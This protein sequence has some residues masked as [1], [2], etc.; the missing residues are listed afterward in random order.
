MSD[1]SNNN[2]ELSECISTTSQ[3]SKIQVNSLNDI[4]SDDKEEISAPKHSESSITDEGFCNLN[5]NKSNSTNCSRNLDYRLNLTSVEQSSNLAAVPEDSPISQMALSEHCKI[6][7]GDE[8]ICHTMENFNECDNFANE[9][10]AIIKN[11][12]EQPELTPSNGSYHES[13]KENRGIGSHHI[14]ESNAS[15]V[16]ECSIATNATNYSQRDRYLSQIMTKTEAL[17]ARQQVALWLTRTSM[18]DLSSMPSLKNLVYPPSVA[19]REPPSRSSQSSYCSCY[20]NGHDR[21]YQKKCN[22]SANCNRLSTAMSDCCVDG[23][24]TT[25]NNTHHRKC[26]A[27]SP[28]KVNLSDEKKFTAS[29]NSNI[30]RNHSTKSLI[31]GF[32]F[33]FRGVGSNKTFNDKS[34][35]MCEENK[36]LLPSPIAFRKCETVIALTGTDT[37]SPGTDAAFDDSGT[38]SSIATSTLIK[39]RHHQHYNR[40]TSH[41]CSVNNVRHHCGHGSVSPSVKSTPHSSKKSTSLSLLKKLSSSKERS[42]NR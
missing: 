29:K 1:I 16:S 10:S 38:Y 37:N 24:G 25:V 23:R 32:S 20:Y 34:E 17:T 27:T 41:S 8:N 28:S 5:D 4:C 39:R 18:S 40:P 3:E 9:S 2:K 6:D 36:S 35:K 11:I 30:K 26:S 12:Y 14:P 19:T 15:D 42:L 22:S 21:L 7:K 31:G 13:K 33:G